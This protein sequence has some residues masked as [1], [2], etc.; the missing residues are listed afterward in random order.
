MFKYLIVSLFL[1][2]LLVISI[3]FKMN[4]EQQAN[5]EGEKGGEKQGY[6]IETQIIEIADG[7]GAEKKE[8]KDFFWGIGVEIRYSEHLGYPAH[9][10]TSVKSGYCAESNNILEGDIIYL[11]ND[12][13]LDFINDIKGDEPKKLKLTINRNGSIIIKVFNRC[14]V[15]Y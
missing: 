11:V 2:L 12:Q 7:P 10:V 15:Y 14:K 6:E 13:P 8:L 5:T 9:I 4:Q 3:G 1:H